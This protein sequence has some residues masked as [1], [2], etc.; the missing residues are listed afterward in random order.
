MVRLPRIVYENG[1]EKL[2]L[3][4]PNKVASLT[5]LKT[6]QCAEFIKRFAK[7]IQWFYF[8]HRKQ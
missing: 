5:V 7:A 1:E 4:V 3:L 8:V 6:L 2:I